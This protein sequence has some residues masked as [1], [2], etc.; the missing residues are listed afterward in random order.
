MTAMFD[1]APGDVLSYSSGT[2]QTGL[3]GFQKLRA[4]PSLLQAALKRWPELA[5]PFDQRTPMFINAYP[6]SIGMISTGISVDT[7]LIPRV[8]WRALQLAAS[9]ARPVILCGQSLF[10]ASALL[11]HVRA[12]RELPDTLLLLVGGYQTP[13]SLERT[14]LALLAPRVRHLTLLQGYGVA[15]VDAGCMMSRGRDA[16]GRPI[17]FPR[18]DVDVELDGPELLLSL[19]GPAGE[20]VVDRWRTGDHAER[21]GEGWAIWNHRRLHPSVETALE[22]WTNADWRRRTGYVRRDGDT[23][24]IQLRPGETPSHDGE[25]DHWDFARAFGFSWLDK[26]CWR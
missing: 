17:F 11:D 2:H 19:R 14:L 7:Y 9:A 24:R 10:L 4:R 16:T 21:R 18:K 8:M 23:L 12:E 22:S 26:P 5:A 25:L 15:E 1:L 20:R 3:E 13:R 6:A